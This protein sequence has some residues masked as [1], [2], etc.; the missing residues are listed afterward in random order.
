M[1]I[2]HKFKYADGVAHVMGATFPGPELMTHV[3]ELCGNTLAT[4]PMPRVVP[5]S[6]EDSFSDRRLATDRARSSMHVLSV[7][8]AQYINGHGQSAEPTELAEK[9]ELG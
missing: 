2:G 8:G 3:S 6:I 7:T 1:T 9:G 4:R 5:R